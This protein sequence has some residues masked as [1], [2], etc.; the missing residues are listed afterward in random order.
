MSTCLPNRAFANAREQCGHGSKS[1][2]TTSSSADGATA[3]AMG[4]SSHALAVPGLDAAAGAAVSC[5]VA[6]R[7][8]GSAA[9]TRRESPWYDGRVWARP[10]VP[11]CGDV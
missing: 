2:V 3:A 10:A 7:A 1:S 6:P 8:A 11:R 9:V 4:R 5:V